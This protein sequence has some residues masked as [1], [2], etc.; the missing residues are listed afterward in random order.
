[1]EL[2][3]QIKGREM[4]A[5]ALTTAAGG[6]AV[7]LPRSAGPQEWADLRDWQA[8]ARQRGIKFYLIWDWLVREE[9][10]P[11]AAALL[12]AAAD[13][14]PDALVLR[15][16]GIAAHAQRQYA[17]LRLH[18]A[19]NWGILN[20]PGLRLAQ[21]L[22]F[23]RVVLDHPI[24]LKDLGLMRRQAAMP[25]EVMLPASCQGFSGLCL[26]EEYLG[27]PCEGCPCSP[28]PGT[29][30][31]TLMAALEMLSGLQQLG[32]EAVQ[33]RGELFPGE[34]LP[35]VA[36]LYHRVGQ[37]P[38][39]ERARV[40][41]AARE[42]LLA[43]GER[44]QS[45]IPGKAG[46]SFELSP[47]KQASGKRRAVPL[48]PSAGA[49]PRRFIWLEARG[50]E[51]AAALA[52]QWREP[53]LV[54]LTAAN[55]AAFLKEHRRWEPRR[56]RWRL[57]PVIRE[58]EVAFYQKALD[59]LRQGG[60]HHFLAPDWGAVALAGAAG[61]TLYGDQTLGVR[62]SWALSAAGQ[63]GVSKCCLPPGPLARLTQR[64]LNA[65]PAGSFWAY[66]Y[67]VPALAV[68]PAAAAPPAPAEGLRW[69]HREENLLLS[70]GVPEFLEDAPGLL[71]RHDV[72]PLIVALPR[73]GLP[74]GRVPPE[75]GPPPE[76]GRR[77]RL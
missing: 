26:L 56:L 21:T 37:A 17:A 42:A 19:G 62:N 15:D 7:R 5:T 9:E 72:A 33:V 12:A 23:G 6:V 63:L 13:L 36:E 16:L 28:S 74:W 30:L 54:E 11:G 47:E 39:V 71:K 18:A 1:M 49:L 38:P 68:C 76:A 67:H 41:A 57:P 73:S 4:L 45:A 77:S 69:S 10:L 14:A 60:Y 31:D 22:G 75:L 40:L 8:R 27:M 34:S 20:S 35:L 51:E 32:V 2:V 58:S 59:T 70:R 43:A 44:F 52:H 3:L 50:Y 29:L 64:W 25:L 61:D 65:A 66:L 46:S 53:L 48:N 55:Y 24:S